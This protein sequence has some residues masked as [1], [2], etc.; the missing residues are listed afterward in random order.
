MV[1][2]TVSCQTQHQIYNAIPHMCNGYT[3]GCLSVSV[4]L[5][6]TEDTNIAQY[7]RFRPLESAH[8][9]WIGLLSDNAKVRKT[10][11][12]WRCIKCSHFMGHAI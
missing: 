6:D 10:D 1:Q 4:A 9:V 2:Q 8:I 11:S 5:S 7:I 3:G 12:K